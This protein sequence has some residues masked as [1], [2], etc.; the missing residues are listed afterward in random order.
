[1]QKGQ[2]LG[3]SALE[4]SR[5]E[6]VSQPRKALAIVSSF[7]KSTSYISRLLQAVND[8]ASLLLP[9]AANSPGL[10]CTLSVFSQATAL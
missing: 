7:A 1:M 10:W 2:K 5:A 9:W 4:M 8:A 6:V 3:L